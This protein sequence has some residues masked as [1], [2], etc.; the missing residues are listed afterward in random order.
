MGIIFR[1]TLGY[2]N[3]SSSL[4]TFSRPHFSRFTLWR[5][6]QKAELAFAG[7]GRHNIGGLVPMPLNGL[8]VSPGPFAAPLRRALGHQF[9]FITGIASPINGSSQER[10]AGGAWGM[11]LAVPQVECGLH[12]LP[13]RA[14]SS[15][16][17]TQRF[18]PP[19]VKAEKA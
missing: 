6:Y 2:R 10:V 4:D 3:D 11:E 16:Q 14:S 9:Q 5:I 13:M 18:Q 8:A 15:Q 12:D 19:L 17:D 1:T 7:M